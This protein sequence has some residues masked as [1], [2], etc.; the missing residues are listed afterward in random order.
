MTCEPVLGRYC[1]LS[2]GQAVSVDSC[3]GHYVKCAWPYGPGDLITQ[4]TSKPQAAWVLAPHAPSPGWHALQ[5][6]AVTIIVIMINFLTIVITPVAL[7]ITWVQ[8]FTTVM[9]RSYLVHS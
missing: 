3:V 4:L 2:V 5:F 1:M 9:A 7:F 8:M 6:I